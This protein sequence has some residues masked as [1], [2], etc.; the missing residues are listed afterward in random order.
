[1]GSLPLES[2]WHPPKSKLSLPLTWPLYQLRR[3]KQ[4]SLLSV[5]R[6]P[7]TV[8]GQ[9]GTTLVREDVLGFFPSCLP[10]GPPSLLQ[11][12]G[13]AAPVPCFPL[14]FGEVPAFSREV[15]A[16]PSGL[17]P[18]SA[19]R[20]LVK[21]PSAPDGTWGGVFTVPAVQMIEPPPTCLQNTA[22]ALLW[23]HSVTPQG[24]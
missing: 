16:L 13:G 3:G 15:N 23:R 5:T 20:P 21:V 2:I 8:S 1:M 14:S 10:H 22:C 4:L 18:L 6:L 17:R 7:L 24:I 9:T 19:S 12:Q 11:Q